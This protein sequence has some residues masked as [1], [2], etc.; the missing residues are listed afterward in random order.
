[1]SVTSTN[2]GAG[3]DVVRLS[4]SDSKVRDVS[5]D[6][7]RRVVCN[8]NQYLPVARLIHRDSSALQPRGAFTLIEFWW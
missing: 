4:R 2:Q 5:C 7:S 1:M 6:Q 3:A 8:P